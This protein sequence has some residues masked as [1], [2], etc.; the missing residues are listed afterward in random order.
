MPTKTAGTG[1]TRRQRDQILQDSETLEAELLARWDKEWIWHPFTQMSEWEKEEPCIIESGRGCYLRDVKGKR[2]FDGVSSLWCNLHGHRVHKLDRAI[3]HQLKRVAHSTFLGLSNV[4][5]IQ[6][7]KRLIEIAPAGLKRVFYS[8]SGSEAVE[9]A[10]KMAYQYWQ[11]KG[12]TDR[13][14][15][16][17]L[18]N[19]YHGDTIGAVSV[20]GIELFHSVYRPLL[21]EAIPVPA[22]Y[23]YRDSFPGTEES[24]RE[25]CLKRLEESI[26]KHRGEICALIMEPLIQGAAGMITHPKGYLAGAR[27]LTKKHGILLIADEVA[28]G[29]G[30]TGRMFACEHENVTPDILCLAKGLTGGYVPL[31]AT[32]TT[33]EIYAAFL[34]RHDEFKTFFHGHTYTA[35]PLACATALANLQIFEQDRTLEKLKPKIEFLTVA[36]EKL[37]RLR[38]V[39]DIRQAGFMAGIELVRDRSDKTAYEAAEKVG[40]RVAKEAKSL[41]VILRP[42][43]NVVVLMPPLASTIPMLKRLMRV[44][45][46]S[47]RAATER[48]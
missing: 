32:L 21:F 3:R 18:T 41:R 29:F 11:L 27:E 40:M 12:E 9:I 36:L 48:V 2:Y 22:P 24:Y 31:A 10:L 7:A 6:L 17:H 38:H 16:L 42:L 35:N 20:G 45:N 1:K 13:K 43:G 25:Q 5:A 8:D 37:R 19:A 46:R 15:F 47:I 14:K 39:G 4:P 34:G 44:V 33:E 26:L 30:R 23:Q 28:T